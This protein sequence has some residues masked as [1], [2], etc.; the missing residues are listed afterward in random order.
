MP[1]F[2]HRW[3]RRLVLVLVAVAATV[4]PG[5]AMAS[6][7]PPPPPPPASATPGT[8]APPA[9]SSVPVAQPQ[10]LSLNRAEIR[11]VWM[12]GN[13]MPVLRDRDRM[14]LAV[15]QLARLNFNTIY[16]V[17]WNSG[18]AYYAS[19]STQRR[20]I[21]SFTFRGLQGQDVLAELIQAGHAKGLLVIPWFEFGFMAPPGSELARLHPQWLTRKQDGGLTS[22]SAAGEVVWLNPLHPDVQ[23]FIL[24]LVQEIISQYDGDGI[25]FDDHM[26]LPSDFGYDDVTT[27]LYRKDTRKA[28]PTNPRDPAWLKWRADKISDFMQR[29]H[30][31]V[32]AAKPS[33]VVSVSPNYY[34]FA[35]K[36]QLQDWLGWIRRGLVDELIVQLYRPDLDS[37]L[38][39]LAEAAL[40]ESRTRIPTAVAIMTGQR[41]RLVPMEL[42]QAQVNAVR[43]RQLGVAFFYFET[44][45]D[46]AMEPLSERKLAFQQLFP[47]PAPRSMI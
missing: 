12:T 28:P 45:W 32:H 34:D 10:P 47:S 31:T 30:D 20:G 24:E 27:A 9:T 23:A 33:A 22:I 6:F 8:V 44:L 17:V 18:I 14:Q 40:L 3:L 41:Q 35:Y 19:A 26:S 11:G 7:P 25:Q 43:E 5:F 16:P 39:L 36:L 1:F 46:R 21:Q 13:D 4:L 2:R 42:I 38:P 37:F 29:V 15:E